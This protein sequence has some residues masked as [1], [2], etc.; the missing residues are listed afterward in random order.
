MQKKEIIARFQDKKSAD[1]FAESANR[2]TFESVIVEQRNGLWEVRLVPVRKI[3]KFE[4][5]N[6]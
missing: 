3:P 2:R 4:P 1:N 5:P 6:T